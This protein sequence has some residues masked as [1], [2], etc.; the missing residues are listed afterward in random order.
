MSYVVV[1]S[2]EVAGCQP[3][4]VVTETELGLCNIEALVVAG[5]IAKRQTKISKQEETPIEEQ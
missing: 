2:R 3:G 5:H 1:G 4:A